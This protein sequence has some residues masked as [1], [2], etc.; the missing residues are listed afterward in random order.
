MSATTTM[1]ATTA[2]TTQITALLGVPYVSN[3]RNIATDGGLDCWGLVCEVYRRALAVTLPPFLIA[4]Q[5]LRRVEFDRQAGGG[6]RWRRS[7]TPTPYAVALYRLASGAYHCGVV[8]PC[9]RRF[10]HCRAP[11]ALIEALDAAPWRR[12]L[13]GYYEYEYAHK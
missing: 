10:I 8:L 7:P 3:G 13:K 2:M 9:R 1:T 5:D 4:D 12:L 11:V 6:N